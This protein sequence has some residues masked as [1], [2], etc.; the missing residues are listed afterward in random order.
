MSD[1]DSQM[2]LLESNLPELPGDSPFD[3]AT[4]SAPSSHS[5]SP[6]SPLQARQKA[7]KAGET[8]QS[9]PFQSAKSNKH[10]PTSADATS[11]QEALRQ[12]GM[13]HFLRKP[14]TPKPESDENSAVLA[15]LISMGFQNKEARQALERNNHNLESALLELIGKSGKPVAPKVRTPVSPEDE[16]ERPD[17]PGLR[18]G[19]FLSK[20]ANDSAVK[21]K[22]KTPQKYSSPGE[23]EIN[24]YADFQEEA[25]RLSREERNRAQRQKQSQA[26][27]ERT[28]T[29][30]LSQKTQ[31]AAEL[32]KLLNEKEAECAGLH[33]KLAVESKVSRIAQEMLER[34]QNKNSEL[35]V[36]QMELEDAVSALDAENDELRDTIEQLTMANNEQAQMLHGLVNPSESTGPKARPPVQKARLQAMLLASNLGSSLSSSAAP[37]P[38]IKPRPAPNETWRCTSCTYAH[39]SEELESCMMC[40]QIRKAGEVMQSDLTEML[41][42]IQLHENEDNRTVNLLGNFMRANIENPFTGCTTGIYSLTQLAHIYLRTGPAEFGSLLKR[43]GIS[44]QF[45]REQ[46]LQCCQR[47]LR[48][49]SD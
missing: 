22:M 33:D 25:Q 18:H 15:E 8:E 24:F 37:T 38:S 40:Q 26:E 20:P 49:E 28:N 1:E 2:G 6:M 35:H 23:L 12:Q 14:E 29:Q 36:M 31:E 7:K 47:I 10:R 16:P 3:G 42:D 45:N 17:S 9:K 4:R 41:Q 21:P 48:S 34:C 44:K 27:E 11:I 30:R 39:N 46:L 32:R 13:G 5:R 19:F 43:L